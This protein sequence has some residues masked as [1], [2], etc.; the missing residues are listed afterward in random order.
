MSDDLQ[1]SIKRLGRIVEVRH[2]FTTV[3]EAVFREAEGQVHRLVLADAELERQIQA[4]RAEIAHNQGLTGRDVQ[5][6][7]KYIEG[8]E[9]KRRKILQSIEKAKSFVEEKRMEWVERLREER[10]I[11]KVQE[12]RLQEWEREE[13]LQKQKAMDDAF[14]GRLVRTRLTR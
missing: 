12:R 4:V 8:L 9:F 1:S 5:G 7:E 2:T 13:E 10:V 6:N 3:A 14:I 11:E